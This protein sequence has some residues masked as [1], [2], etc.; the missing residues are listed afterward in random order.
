[1]QPQR[2][3]LHVYYHR[4]TPEPPSS[5]SRAGEEEEEEEEEDHEETGAETVE[6]EFPSGYSDPWPEEDNEV[7]K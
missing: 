6:M 7:R 2:Q 5:S 3:E 1:M 4:N